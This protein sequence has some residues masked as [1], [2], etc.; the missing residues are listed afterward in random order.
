MLI[1]GQFLL[2]NGA[3][4]CIIAGTIYTGIERILWMVQYAK[5]P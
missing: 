5:L 4:I 1:Y 2:N 3:Y